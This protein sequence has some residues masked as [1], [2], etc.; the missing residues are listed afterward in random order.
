[1]GT[2]HLLAVGGTLRSNSS[3]EKALRHVLDC[4]VGLGAT[5]ELICGHDLDLPPYSPEDPERTDTA[6]QLI[7]A[8]RRADAVVIGSPGYHGGISGLVKN[9]LDYTEDLRNDPSPYFDSRPIGCIA[10]G[11]G[12]Q[13]AVSTLSAMRNVVHALRGWNTPVGVPINTIDHPFADDGRCVDA[14]IAGALN[15][16]ARQLVEFHRDRNAMASEHR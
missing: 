14:K 8:F 13:G 12:W 1:M 6:R 9:A 15:L 5:V 16:M 11:A 4:A 3:T 7:A 2:C 10:T